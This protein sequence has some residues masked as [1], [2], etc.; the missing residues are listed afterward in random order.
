MNYNT[1][2]STIL[3]MGEIARY[4]TQAWS[5]SEA[6][7]MKT[8]HSGSGDELTFFMKK[9]FLVSF[10]ILV[11][12]ASRQ[13]SYWF[14]LII[15]LLLSLFLFLTKYQT[16]TNSLFIRASICLSHGDQDTTG[17][18]DMTQAPA[19]PRIE[20]IQSHSE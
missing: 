4:S 19:S 20:K 13:R 18:P 9:I 7:L 2:V 6:E 12:A 11:Q 8:E 10:K 15:W 16:P 14:L 17:N 3:D 1:Q 5:F